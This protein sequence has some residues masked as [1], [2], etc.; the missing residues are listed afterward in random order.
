VQQ[1]ALPRSERRRDPRQ[2]KSFAFWLRAEGGG[3]PVSAW[4]L[5]MSTGGAAFLTPA[6]QAPAVGTRITF[7]EMP[8]GDRIVRED[9]APL[10]S[11]ARVLRHEDGGGVTC[12]VAVR[13]ESGARA[14]RP[15]RT[16]RAARNACT[17]VRYA[18]VPPPVPASELPV[19]VPLPSP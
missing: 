17:G 4:M 1:P 3:D 9:A 13:F 11:A 16:C 15:G 10:P 12:K 14:R 7:L 8:T 6:G 19:V 2:P 5:N 18:L